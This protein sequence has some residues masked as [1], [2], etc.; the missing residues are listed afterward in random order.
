MWSA[1]AYVSLASW[2]VVSF[3]YQSPPV[4]Y[5]LPF[6]YILDSIILK[7]RYNSLYNIINDDIRDSSPYLENNKE[8]SS[9][10]DVR[11]SCMI[12]SYLVHIGLP[13]LLKI[14]KCF[15]WCSQF[16]VFASN[17]WSWY[18][19][20]WSKGIVI[21]WNITI[22]LTLSSNNGASWTLSTQLVVAFDWVAHFRVGGSIGVIGWRHGSRH[23]R[24]IWR[25]CTSWTWLD[26]NGRRHGMTV[27][28]KEELNNYRW[29]SVRQV[30]SCSPKIQPTK[31]MGCIP[32]SF[33]SSLFFFSHTL[34]HATTRRRNTF[35]WY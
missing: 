23:W 14:K 25:C 8:R 3:P 20:L 28:K 7:D 33:Y 30:G 27:D 13:A 10:M 19:R 24:L 5:L 15:L 2:R 35:T 32:L 1:V 11:S 12:L 18:I 6:Q 21:E 31:T 34:I 26:A 17:G 16:D 22:Q 29:D 4:L 9:E